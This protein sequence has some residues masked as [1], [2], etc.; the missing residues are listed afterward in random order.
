M[1]ARRS[2]LNIEEK[3]RSLRGFPAYI[4]RE[5]PKVGRLNRRVRERVE[6]FDLCPTIKLRRFETGFGETDINVE[7]RVTDSLSIDSNGH[8]AP[9]PCTK[10]TRQCLFELFLIEWCFMFQA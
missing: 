9:N 3:R 4:D 1:L 6:I 5:S 8:L 2:T 7:V 10:P